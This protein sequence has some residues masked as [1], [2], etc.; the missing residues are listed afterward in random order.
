[1]P[2]V[3]YLP[4]PNASGVVPHVIG[5]QLGDSPD[6]WLSFWHVNDADDSSFHLMNIQTHQNSTQKALF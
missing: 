5:V 2:P 1:M 6:H 3:L 4:F